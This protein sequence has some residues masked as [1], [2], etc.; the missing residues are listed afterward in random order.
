MQEKRDPWDIRFDR[1]GILYT[2]IIYANSRH[3]DAVSVTSSPSPTLPHANSGVLHVE[4]KMMPALARMFRRT[5]DILL[6]L[7]AG[8]VIETENSTLQDLF[9]P[10]VV[11]KQEL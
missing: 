5:L 6:F 10:K 7:E 9:N 11:E 1:S 3:S 2:N 4:L 8:A